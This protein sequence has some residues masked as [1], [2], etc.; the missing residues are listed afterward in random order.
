[1]IK[2]KL[3]KLLKKGGL[4][5]LLDEV[6]E[7]IGVRYGLFDEK[8]RLLKGED[9]QED[10]MSWP[11]MHGERELGILFGEPKAELLVSLFRNQIAHEHEKR[12]LGSETLDKYREIN[13]LYDLSEKVGACT[14]RYA[15]GQ[16]ITQ[17]A[18]RFFKA[19]HITLMLF[20]EERTHLEIL[21]RVGNEYEGID[22]LPAE[23]GF[24]GSIA[25]SG[26]AEIN[27][28]IQKDPRYKRSTHPIYST[29]CAPLKNKE[30]PLGVLQ[31]STDE[32]HRYTA[33][34]L[35]LL[36]TLTYQSAAAV[37][38]VLLLEQKRKEEQIKSHL[39]RY[40]ASQ[41]ADLIASQESLVLAPAK[42]GIAILFSDIRNFTSQC[43]RLAPEKIVNYLN[44]Y[45]THMVEVI[46]ENEGTVDKFVGDMIVALFG[47]PTH[48]DSFEKHAILTAIQ[49]Q[50]KLKQ[51]PTDWIQKHFHT[52]IGISS[53]DV[54]VGNIGSPQHMDYTAI[55]DE[56]NTASR[57]QSLAKGGQI[58]VSRSIYESTQSLFHF[59]EMGHLQVKG[60]KKPIEVFEVIY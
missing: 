4:S 43:E 2:I 55:G 59:R 25:L 16:L 40:V 47:A 41:V 13:M 48:L 12:Q 18:G 42:K 22:S 27:N 36:T 8:G 26:K 17:E 10:F 9:A 23:E 5:L 54:V 44:E 1:M 32:I 53:G 39:K 30:E 38:N 51:M 58:L 45:F 60:K 49:M 56:V 50:E 7:A 21:E 15:L 28:H 35:K 24:V 6:A 14:D 46:F 33:G 3:N 31:L 57:L 20:N 19:D 11:I 29:I 37:E 34:D 52:G